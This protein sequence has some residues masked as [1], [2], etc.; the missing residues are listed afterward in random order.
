VT[1]QPGRSRTGS[2]PRGNAARCN[3]RPYAGCPGDSPN[4]TNPL[5]WFSETP[6]HGEGDEARTRARSRARRPE[7][8]RSLTSTSSNGWNGPARSQSRPQGNGHD[9]KTTGT[10]R[11]DAADGP[12]VGRGVPK[13][14]VTTPTTGPRSRK[15]AKVSRGARPDE[16]RARAAG[17]L[18]RHTS[19]SRVDSREHGQTTHGAGDPPPHSPSTGWPDPRVRGLISPKRQATSVRGH[20]RTIPIERR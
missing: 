17:K 3:Y 5:T 9:S 15:A 11:S 2:R 20:E 4:P 12:L 16:G 14:S 1:P 19:S 6:R 13:V 18:A 10:A 8:P 7:W